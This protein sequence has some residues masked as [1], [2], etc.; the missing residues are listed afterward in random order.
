M[1]DPNFWRNR[2]TTSSSKQPFDDY[3]LNSSL[4]RN[5]EQ[6]GGVNIS[7]DVINI[8]GDVV[9][10][11]KVTTLSVD[12]LP[13]VY[14]IAKIALDRGDIE[15]AI[16]N[17]AK[18]SEAF[19]GYRDTEKLLSLAE[20]VESKE[21]QIKFWLIVYGCLIGGLALTG[22]VYASTESG[23]ISFFAAIVGIIGGGIGAYL[24]LNMVFPKTMQ[25]FWLRFGILTPTCI[26]SGLAGLLIIL[27][28]LIILAFYA[29]SQSK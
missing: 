22:L 20:H 29:I 14:K 1:S 18:I 16:E 3:W 26:V 12:E 9:G 5:I 6:S 13:S 25:S 15:K 11:D 19:P 27:V 8:G 23:F 7:G 28:A 2:K 24:F 4:G 17:F 21:K 10:R